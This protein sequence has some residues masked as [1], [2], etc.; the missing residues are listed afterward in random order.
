MTNLSGG[1]NLARLLA[2]PTAPRKP[3]RLL[4]LVLV[5]LAIPFMGGIAWAIGAAAAGPVAGALAVLAGAAVPVLVLL[6]ALK[7]R[8][9]YPALLGSWQK[10]MSRWHKLVYCPR[11][12]SVSNCETGEVASAENMATLVGSEAWRGT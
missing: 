12:H 10:L 7:Y 8:H 5:P 11:C 2:P 6:F 4:A 9:R 3:Y 1:T